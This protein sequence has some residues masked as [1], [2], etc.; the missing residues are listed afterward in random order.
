M[1]QIFIKETFPDDHSVII[2]VD[3]V[4]YLKSIPVLKE[5]YQRYIDEDR[6]ILLDLSGL[7][8][9][10]REGREFLQGI[11]SKVKF[12]NNMTTVELS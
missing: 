2:Q 1:P 6:E 10:T 9:I 4:L 7:T 5:I 8:Y 3:G 11:R 12:L